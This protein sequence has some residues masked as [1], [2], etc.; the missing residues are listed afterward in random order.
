[1]LNDYFQMFDR[2]HINISLTL[3][4][5]PMLY[6]ILCYPCLCINKT[7]IF[8]KLLKIQEENNNNN[9]TNQHINEICLESK[10]KIIKFKIIKKE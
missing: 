9:L 3:L 5:N 2:K 7:R 4:L 6:C 1:M 10:Q 8:N